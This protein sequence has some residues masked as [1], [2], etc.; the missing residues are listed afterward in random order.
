MVENS[1]DQDAVDA[2]V[3]A[4]EQRPVEE[5]QRL[6][7]GSIS[8]STSQHPMFAGR[9]SSSSQPRPS[10]RSLPSSTAVVASTSY[11]WWSIGLL[12]SGRVCLSGSISAGAVPEG[13]SS[14]VIRG[15]E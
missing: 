11:Q 14:E 5:E 6:W 13:M 7:T 8:A 1:E 4:V 2:A 12:G 3:A 15:R 9:S 10:Q